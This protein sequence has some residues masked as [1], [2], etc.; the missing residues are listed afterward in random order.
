MPIHGPKKVMRMVLARPH[1]SKFY[2]ECVI[3]QK[4]HLC[5]YLTLSFNASP[6]QGLYMHR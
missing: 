4:I 3:N 1:F 2:T 5:H 6:V